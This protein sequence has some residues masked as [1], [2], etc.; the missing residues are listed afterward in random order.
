[1]LKERGLRRA[2]EF[3]EERKARETI[4]VYHQVCN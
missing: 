3:T 2:S 4:K 1:L